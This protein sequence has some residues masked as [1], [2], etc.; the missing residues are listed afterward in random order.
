MKKKINVLSLFDGISCGRQALER[1]GFNVGKY[2]ASEIHEPSIL[3]AKTR[4]PDIKHVGD[5]RYLKG[6][7]F[8]DV[9]ILM[10]GSPCQ[11]FSLC[12]TRKGMV[13]IQNEEVTE[14]SHYLKLKSEGFVFHGE[15]Y[16][17]WELV[18]LLEEIRV[19][20]PNVIFLLE[21][22]QMKKK[23]KDIISSALGVQPIAINSSVMSAQNRQRLYWTN[24]NIKPIVDLNITFDQIIPGAIAAGERGIPTYS[25]SGKRYWKKRTMRKDGKSNCVVCNP[26]STN[27]Y[28]LNGEYHMITPEHAEQLQTIEVGFTNVKGVS[29]TERYKMVGN[30]WTVDVISHIFSSIK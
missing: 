9:H 27:R 12:G 16:L 4:Y 8:K 19:Y 18:R 11:N 24:I 7:D 25:S 14:L 3:V 21:N 2:Y 20:N 13:T 5:V 23:W 15:S 10:G 17:F 22:V 1:S 30:A 28:M 29:N 6:E 26:H